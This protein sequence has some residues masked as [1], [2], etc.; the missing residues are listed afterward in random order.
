MEVV[1]CA[2]DLRNLGG[3][4]PYEITFLCPDGAVLFKITGEKVS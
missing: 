1:G 3:K 4:S 2:G